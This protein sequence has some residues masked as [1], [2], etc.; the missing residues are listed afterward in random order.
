LFRYDGSQVF[1]EEKRYGFFPGVSAGWRLSE[2]D[3]I[4]NSLPFIN[5]L[6]IRAS[7]GELGNDKIN[8]YQ[9][10]QTYTFGNNY[11]FGTSDAPGLT[12]GVL[13]NPDVT[14]ERAKKTDIGLET[15]LGMV[16]WALT[17]PIGRRN[18]IIF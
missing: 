16:N 4:K 1:P 14:W 6:K 11:V 3:F 13:A 8:P 7:Y 12:P 2:E 18:E 10:L 17:L 9:Y 5:Q 15:Q